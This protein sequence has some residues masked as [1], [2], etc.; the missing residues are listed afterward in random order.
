MAIGTDYRLG[1]LG[2]GQLG[3]MLIPPAM[4]LNISNIILDP[5][6]NAPCREYA[7]EFIV[8]KLTDKEAVLAFA[9]NLD[10]L[11]IEIENVSVDAM[12]EL[13]SKGL[14]VFPQPAVVQLIQDKGLQKNFYSEQGIPTAP[15]Q[16]VSGKAELAE[17]DLE[18]P[19]ILKLR[20]EGYDGRGVMKLDSAADLENAFD[21]PCVLEELIPFEKELAVIVNRNE[22]GEMKTFPCVEMEFHPV[23]NLVEFLF[24]PANI[25]NAIELKAEAVALQTAEALGIIGTLAVELFLTKEGDIL[26]NEIAPRVHNSGHHTIEGNVTSQFEQHIR[27]VTGQPLGD[28]RLLVPSVMINLLGEAGFEGEAKYEGLEEVM[29]MPGVHVHLY[30]KKFTRPFR[31]MGHVTVTNANLEAAKATARS[32][33]NILKVKA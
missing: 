10:A 1:I 33:K 29:Q 27:S 20:T 28:T 18:Y 30:G 13:E 24:C 4:D 6:P 31:K 19:K 2:G 14:K 26:V 17:M 23:Q 25:S 12:K 5:D 16:L 32:I 3:K 7:S 15:Y 9:Q 21:A 8:G 22:Q 11:T